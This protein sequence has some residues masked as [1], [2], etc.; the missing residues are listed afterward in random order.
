MS[1][2][3]KKKNERTKPTINANNDAPTNETMSETAETV[4]VNDSEENGE[5]QPAS[6]NAAVTSVSVPNE[7]IEMNTAV[8]ISEGNEPE[9]EITSDS[10]QLWRSNPEQTIA[11]DISDVSTDTVIV[12][13]V[14]TSE[15]NAAVVENGVVTEEATVPED[16]VKKAPKKT[17]NA[18]TPAE[19]KIQIAA[20]CYHYYRNW[21][22]DWLRSHNVPS[23]R[24]QK[25]PESYDGHITVLESE[26]EHAIA[27]LELWK[28]E[29]P[30]VKEMFWDLK[31]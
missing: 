17:G 22:R 13:N 23:A 12:E 4:I 28:T 29:N 14:P 1:S 25:S 8:T 10:F 2:K 16:K 24:F 30:D 5:E 31:K 18:T 20:S 19:K 7:V 15:P 26:K 11:S 9:S 6:D 27:A 3:N 21:L